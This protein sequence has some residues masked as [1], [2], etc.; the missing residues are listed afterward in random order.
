MVYDEDDDRSDNGDEYTPQINTGD[1]RGTQRR[2]D[3]TAYQSTDYSQ[4]NVTDHAFATL[5]D[6]FA[7]DEPSD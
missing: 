6:Y 7:A 5:V 3:R 2:K 4:D 1:A